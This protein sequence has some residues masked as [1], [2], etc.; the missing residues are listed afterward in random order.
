M[1][2][3][4]V[5]SASL[6]AATGTMAG[7]SAGATKSRLTGTSNTDAEQQLQQQVQ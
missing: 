5:W 7:A 6:D 2:S 4:R 1:K 3:I